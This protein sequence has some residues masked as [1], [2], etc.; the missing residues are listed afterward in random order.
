MQEWPRPKSLKELRD[1]LEPT[2]YYRRFVQGYG[3]LAWLLINQRKHNLCWD[4]N[5][6]LAF[7][8]LKLAMTTIL[9]LA[10]P[11]IRQCFVLEIDALGHGMGAV[12]IEQQRPIAYF[13]QDLTVAT[14]SK[15]IYE[16]ELMDIVLAIQKWCHYLLGQRFIVC[17]DQRILKYLLEQC[18]VSMEHQKWL[19]KL[20]GYSKFSTSLD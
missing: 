20:L 2:G 11:D 15:S 14:R 7:K 9:V 19:I 3:N 5:V 6:D 13:S 16:H 1:F 17:T 10:L 4:A 18:L 12:L 8:A